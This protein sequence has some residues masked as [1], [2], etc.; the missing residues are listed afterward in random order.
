V[1]HP[2]SRGDGKSLSVEAVVRFCEAMGDH[3]VL[4]VGRGGPDLA[5]LPENA[6]DWTGYTS[7]PELA[8]L[9]ANS[10]YNV[11]V[12]SG[13][14]HMAAAVGDH[15]L[16]IHSWSDPRKVGPYR[17]RAWVWKR[18]KICRVADMDA[19]FAGGGGEMPDAAAMERIAA[20]VGLA[21]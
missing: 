3:P 15:L 18:D 17:K 7:L 14:A 4:I 10:D 12:D 11:S 5:G 2:F 8:W 20:H 19:D 21:L 16:A 6:A 9:L 1:L 13:P